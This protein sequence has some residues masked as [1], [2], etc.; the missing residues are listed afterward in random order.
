MS[1]AALTQA[2]PL[3]EAALASPSDRR[4]HRRVTFDREVMSL[5]EEASRT[6]MGRDLSMGGM[7]IDAGWDLSEGDEIRL[8][9][10]GAPDDDPFVVKAR[11]VR[12]NGPDGLG[13]AFEGV[14]PEVANRLEAMVAKLPDVESLQ[15]G[16]SEAMGS[17]VSQVLERVERPDAPLCETD[18]QPKT[19]TS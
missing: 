9:L 13:L 3:P 14:E 8:A 17:V 1:S 4:K 11:V 7:S 5:G 2:M 6:L 10:Y 19:G 18:A 12:D 16:E 15:D